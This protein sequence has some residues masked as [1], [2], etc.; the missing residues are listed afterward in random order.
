MNKL[1]QLYNLFKRLDYIFKNSSTKGTYKFKTVLILLIFKSI[2]ETAGIGLIYPFIDLTL[3][4]DLIGN[5]LFYEIALYFDSSIQASRFLLI[6]G[7]GLIIFFCLSTLI[8]VIAKIKAD[9]FIW[10]IN[11]QIIKISF[12][13]YINDPLKFYKKANSNKITHDIINEV[14]VFINGFLVN[15][16][17]LIPKIF[18]LTF[19]VTFLIIIN[20][21]VTLLS[22]IILS[23]FYMGLLGA[24]KRK[25]NTM[26]KQRYLYQNNLLDYVNSSIRAMKDI[27]INSF[28]SYFIKKISVPA[29]KNSMLN[30]GISIYTSLPKFFIESIVLIILVVYVLLNFNETSIVEQ[31]PML[32]LLSLSLIKLLPIIQAMFTNLTR[33]RFNFNSLFVIENNLIINN[34]RLIEPDIEKEEFHSLELQNINFTYESKNILEN[35]NL[36]FD[37][38]DFWLL[39]GESG[40][41]KTTL[42]E[43]MLGFLAPNSGKIKLNNKLLAVE[44]MLSKKINLG[45]VSQDIILFEGDLVENITLKSKNASPIILKKINSLIELC[46]LEDVVDSIGGIKGFISE[47]GKNLSAGQKQ[48]IIIARALFKEPEVLVLDE[49]TSA[50]NANLETQILQRLVD[51]K[52]SIFMITHNENLKAYTDKILVLK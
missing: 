27:K 39:Y 22:L 12:K 48:R 32:S 43:I 5:N 11:T 51:A 6:Y 29:Y 47:G 31:I 13:K 41:G 8:S 4:R 18:L 21:W 35:Q 3:N 2:F 23:L 33:I 34:E 9:D 20:P 17:D 52:I 44:E 15:F 19:M 25:V 10:K 26:S 37:Q 42:T 49:A 40:S 38:G 45:Y 7:I 24:L 28:E 36:R 14:H 30:K 1:K 16:I 46:A 50:L